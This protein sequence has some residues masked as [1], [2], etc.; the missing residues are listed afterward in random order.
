[1]YLHTYI[2]S[3]KKLLFQGDRNK[4]WQYGEN[5]RTKFSGWFP[6]AYTEIVVVEGSP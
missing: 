6:M 5:I 3:V 2:K 4:G 1:M